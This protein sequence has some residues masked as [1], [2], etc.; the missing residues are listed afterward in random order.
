M[1]TDIKSSNKKTISLTTYCGFD[2]RRIQ[3][4]MARDFRKKTLPTDKF[5]DHITL[6]KKQASLLA[7]DLLEFVNG[8]EEPVYDKDYLITSEEEY[9]QH[10]DQDWSERDF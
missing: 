4:T 2:G 3:V 10:I 8:T 5:F 6:S 9:K 7:K 1:S